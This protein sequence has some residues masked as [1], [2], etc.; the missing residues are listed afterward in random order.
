MALISTISP[1]R[2]DIMTALRG[3]LLTV[4]PP[5]TD[6]VIAI[7]NRVPQPASPNHA[8]MTP[9]R[10]K[11]LS[12]N[13]RSY[14]D[15]TFTGS[16]VDAP[17]AF[18]GSIAP[19]PPAFGIVSTGI[20]NVT[21]I[22]SGALLIGAVLS[23]LKVASG[24]RITEQLSGLAGGVG[25]YR[26]SISQ[27]TPSTGIAAAAGVMTVSAMATGSGPISVGAVLSGVGLADGTVITALDTGT[28]GIGTYV[29]TPGQAIAPQT[30]SAG[31]R[32]TTQNS[33]ITVQVDFHSIDGSSADMAQ[34]LSTTFRDPM[35]VDFFA[36]LAPPLNRVAPFFADD[37]K[38]APFRN[39]NQQFEW[40]WICECSM[41][42]NQIV[43][44]DQQFFD[45]IDL[46]VINVD[47]TYPPT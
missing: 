15:V 14:V 18:T 34:T 5:G 43:G 26:V 1:N 25:T 7:E 2:T 39:E 47:A 33:E 4:L 22:T 17:A 12:T 16:V 19:S 40:R 8:I 28:G 36:A 38:L 20:L 24:T 31:F 29:V 27:T 21:A 41:Q 32:G 11:R 45:A 6:A 37:P 30:L 10:F 35:A 3:F 42:V 13:V 23:G 46:A 9:I 44:I